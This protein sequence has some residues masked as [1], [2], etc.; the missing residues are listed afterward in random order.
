MRKESYAQISQQLPFSPSTSL[1]LLHLLTN[2]ALGVA[3]YLCSH[4]PLYVLSQL[5][6]PIF[7][8]RAFALM[9]DCVHGSA[10]KNRFVNDVVGILM[11]ACCFLPYEPWK[12]IHLAHHKW[13]GN[14]DKDP[15]MGLIKSFPLY[16]KARIAILNFCWKTWVPGLAISQ[17]FIFWSKSYQFVLAG[18]KREEKIKNALSVIVPLAVYA[19]VSWT[20][21]IPAVVLY[22][23]MVEVINFP[24]HLQMPMLNGEKSFSVFDQHKTARSCHY[25][26]WFARHVLNNFNLHI[27]HHLYPRLPWYRLEAAQRLV[28]PEAGHEYTAV[29]GNGWIRENRRHGLDHIL[30]ANIAPPNSGQT[31]AEASRAA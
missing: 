20:R 13:A 4:G 18:E 23:A 21:N 1:L 26:R 12:K 14:V 2:A 3:I 22:L 5:L 7:F 9:H 15:S 27:E 16:G 17:H 29:K 8:F 25:P 10:S 31:P 19:C 28:Q 24:H 30:S 11:G 6:L